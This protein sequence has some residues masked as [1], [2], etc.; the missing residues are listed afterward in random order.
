[1]GRRGEAVVED[2]P[3]R[4]CQAEQNEERVLEGVRGLVRTSRRHRH[5]YLVAVSGLTRAR[6]LEEEGRDVVAIRKQRTVDQ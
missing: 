1:V 2:M 4:A 5:G 6:W 3:C